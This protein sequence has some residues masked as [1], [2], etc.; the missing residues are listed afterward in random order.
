VSGATALEWYFTVG[1]A[2]P[3]DPTS[4]PS[5]Y[6]TQIQPRRTARLQ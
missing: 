6:A 1:S 4:Q 5:T 3:D 2:E